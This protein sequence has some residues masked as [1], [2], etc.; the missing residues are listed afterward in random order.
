MRWSEF[1]DLEPDLAERVRRSFDDGRHKTLATLR[2]DGSPRISGIECEFDETDVWIGSMPAARKL[3][4]LRRND[5]VAVHGPAIHP[6]PGEEAA[7]P[8]EAKLAG[9]AIDDGPIEVDGAVMGHRFVIDVT[10][11]VFTKPNDDGTMLVVDF[12]TAA[13]GRQRIERA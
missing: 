11:V 9:R 12:W 13:N 1:A 7:W 2:A 6:A 5:A 3:A 4:D 8:G 10:E